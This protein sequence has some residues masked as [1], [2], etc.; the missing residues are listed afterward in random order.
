MGKPSC[1]M[2]WEQ[3]CGG[4]AAVSLRARPQDMFQVPVIAPSQSKNQEI[5]LLLVLHPFSEQEETLME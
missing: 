4:R 3:G 5:V 2:A 1:S